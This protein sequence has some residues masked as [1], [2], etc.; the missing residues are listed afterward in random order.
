MLKWYYIT[1]CIRKYCMEICKPLCFYLIISKNTLFP[2]QHLIL[3][4]A[5]PILYPVVKVTAWGR[6]WVAGICRDLIRTSFQWVVQ[7]NDGMAPVKRI[8][9]VNINRSL[10]R[11]C[12]KRSFVQNGS[13]LC[14]VP[15][16]PWK[17]PESNLGV[18]V[19]YAN[20]LPSRVK[21]LERGKASG[22]WRDH[23]TETEKTTDSVMKYLFS[24]YFLFVQNIAWASSKYKF[25]LHHYLLR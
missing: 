7:K 10:W 6:W 12:C 23:H 2:P 13:P 8:T 17:V 16:S 9:W 1:L 14:H 11:M 18:C 15:S 24:N 20:S 19:F 21:V 22:I 3:L 5:T 4:Y 25:V